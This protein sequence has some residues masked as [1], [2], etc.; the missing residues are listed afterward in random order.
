M[1][2]YS[3]VEGPLLWIVFLI[4]IVGVAC[5]IFFFLLAII[6]SSEQKDFRWKYIFST[7][8]RALLPF[9]MATPKK[10]VY[11]GLRYI[12]HICMIVVPVWLSGHISLWEESRFEWYWTEIPDSWADGMTLVLLAL[13]AWFIIRRI[14]FGDVRGNSSVMD[15]VLI[16]LT[17]LPFLT[18][19]FLTHGT[20]DAVPFFGD[21]MTLI[22]MLTGEIMILMAVFLFCRTRLNTEKCVACASCVISCPTGTLESKDEGKLRIFKYSHYQCICCGECVKTCPEDAAELRHEISLKRFFQ[23][24]KQQIRSAELQVCERCGT[25]FAPEPQMDKIAKTLTHD[26][27]RFC[28]NCRKANAGDLMQQL[29]PWH[30]KSGKAD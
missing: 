21:N 4:L 8:P 1:D 29:S 5:R 23:I 2:F 24:G 20:L 14:C 3:F 9:H 16:F 15:F 28:P 7:L 17:S 6:K 10:P 13:A 19:Y 22:H 12:F 30:R 25:P 27:L 18:G 11:A 26:Y